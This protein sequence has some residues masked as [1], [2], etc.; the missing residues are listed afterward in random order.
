MIADT[1]RWNTVGLWNEIQTGLTVAAKKFG[2]SVI[3]VGVDTWGVDFALLSKS[4]EVLGL[5]FHYR[6]ARTRGMLA[7][8]L[9]RVPREE[10]FASTGVQLMELNTLYQLLALQKTSPELL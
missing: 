10:I 3:S 9:A 8:A 4:G 1:L 5:P 7:K 2:E 6:D